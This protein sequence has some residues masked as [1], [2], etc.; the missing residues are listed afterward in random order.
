MIG[1]IINI[2]PQYYQTAKDIIALVNPSFFD[3]KR[4]VAVAGESGSGKSVTA[5]CLQAELLQIGIE[6]VILHQDDYFILPPKSNHAARVE[7][8]S[9]VGPQEVNLPILQEHVD[10][11]GKGEERIEKPLINYKEDTILKEIVNISPYQVIIIEGTY[12]FLLN[13]LDLLIFMERTYIE[14]LENRKLRGRE[15]YSQ[16]IEDVLKI[17]HEIIAQALRKA[18]ILIKKDYSVKKL[19]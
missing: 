7:D 9:R 8:I 19:N 10:S 16:F 12:T 2:K 14:T 5:I 6:S 15:P 13:H 17:E 3:E 18:D 11:F 4:V 1:D